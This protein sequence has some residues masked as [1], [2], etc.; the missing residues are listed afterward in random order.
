MQHGA[1]ITLRISDI[2]TR[3]GPYEVILDHMHYLFVIEL[4]RLLHSNMKVESLTREKNGTE[5]SRLKVLIK[6]LIKILIKQ[7]FKTQNRQPPAKRINFLRI[8]LFLFDLRLHHG[9]V[10]V[11]SWGRRLLPLRVGVGPEFVGLEPPLL[12][13]VDWHQNPPL[14][15]CLWICEVL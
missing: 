10:A 11:S 9:P 15:K 6:I 12:R 13:S 5:D 14:F 1:A 4:Q 8:H 7:V 2:S 3:Q